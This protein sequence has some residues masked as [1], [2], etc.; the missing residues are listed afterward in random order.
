MPPRLSPE[1]LAAVLEAQHLEPQESYPGT[2]APWR[3]RC[4]FPTMAGPC[5]WIG[6]IQ[7]EKLRQREWY[8]PKCRTGKPTRLERLAL[9]AVEELRAAGY[10]P[11]EP[12][13]GAN[14]PWPARCPHG[15]TV[16]PRLT[17]L[18]AGRGGCGQCAGNQRLSELHVR[19]NLNAIGL[20]LAGHYVNK[21]SRILIVCLTCGRSEARRLDDVLRTRHGCKFCRLGHM[22]ER[23]ALELAAAAGIEPLEPFPGATKP[24]RCRC[25][26]CGRVL[27]R[28]DAHRLRRQGAC[29]HCRPGGLDYT[30]ASVMYLMRNEIALK[31]GITNIHADPPRA[32]TLA[33]H[34]FV[35]V[36]E[37]HF[38]TGFDARSAETAVLRWARA[39]GMPPVYR[40]EDFAG[41][42]ETFPIGDVD[43]VVAVCRDAWE[44]NAGVAPDPE[45]SADRAQLIETTMHIVTNYCAGTRVSALAAETN[46]PKSA[47]RRLLV[48]A[49]CYEPDRD[50]GD[51]AG[52]Q[53]G[54]RVRRDAE[55]IDARLRQGATITAIAEEYGVVPRTVRKALQ[56]LK[57]R[58][59]E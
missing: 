10:E 7:F 49:G 5:G 36:G 39:Q 29:A 31:V 45:A 9:T 22:D 55:K 44:E 6:T 26:G 3:V 54:A 47:I 37:W 48:N 18:R 21:R 30:A 50:R 33:V 8:C 4:T 16:K 51:A 40:S 35:L 46:W 11:L 32:A 23:E 53:R 41:G 12:Y 20:D 24:W 25:L 57:R 43:E 52:R 1:E 14:E 28:T 58:Q 15:H 2:K 34:G 17:Q 19:K 59:E 56:G 27:P 38:L 42:T 13:P